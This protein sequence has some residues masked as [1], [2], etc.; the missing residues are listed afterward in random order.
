LSSTLDLTSKRGLGLWV[1]GDGSGATMV[2]RLSRFLPKGRDYVVPINFTGRRW[3]EI[4]TGEQGWRAENWGYTS[5]TTKNFDY[6][7]VKHVSIWVGHLP[8]N[9]TCNIL[10]EDLT[11]L[12]EVSQPLVNP[13][14]TLGG[15]SVDINGTIATEN[16]FILEPDGTF[17]V[18]D[19]WWN[20]VYTQ[21]LASA[22]LPSSLASF[23]IQSAS[24]S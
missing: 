20:G 18:Y 12:A 3:I 1:T 6:L 14:I 7:Y 8:A 23:S 13:T 21:Q 24:S 2:I 10:V 19:E 22:L 16:H 4:P 17:T 9:T 11:A 15:Q 5:E